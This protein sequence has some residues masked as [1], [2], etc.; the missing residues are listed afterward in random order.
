M[1]PIYTT[2]FVASTNL[3]SNMDTMYGFADKVGN[4]LASRCFSNVFVNSQE[5]FAFIYDE[6]TCPNLLEPF[7]RHFQLQLNLEG[8][9]YTAPVIFVFFICMCLNI[10]I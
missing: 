5:M 3:K 2:Q 4:A 8:L 6:L 1:D 9:N 7:D 10:F